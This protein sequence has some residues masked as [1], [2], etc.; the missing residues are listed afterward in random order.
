MELHCDNSNTNMKRLQFG[1]NR[2]HKLNIG[3]P[4]HLCPDLCVDNW[5]MVK[6]KFDGDFLMENKDFAKYLADII[7]TNGTNTKTKKD[8]RSKG[9]KRN[10]LWSPFL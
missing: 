3:N 2:C 6:D 7:C 5:K 10:L 8:R 4:D 1:G 9:F